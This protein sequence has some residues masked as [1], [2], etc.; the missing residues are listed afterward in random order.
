MPNTTPI[1]LMLVAVP[2]ALPLLSPSLP[3]TFAAAAVHRRSVISLMSPFDGDGALDDGGGAL[4]EIG[5]MGL[6][7]P[8]EPTTELSPEGVVLSLC[9]GLQHN[10]V[11]H[12]D[13][14][15]E[16]LFRFCTYECKA[17]LTTRKGYKDP[18]GK[19][20]VE[21]A[22]VYTLLGCRSFALVGESTIIAGTPT[23]GALATIAVDVEETLGFRFA[24][25]YE[26]RP[27]GSSSAAAASSSAAA[28]SE[29][30]TRSHEPEVRIER[31]RFT[32][33]QER[34]PPLAGCWMV[35]EL[36][37]MREF[38]LFNGDTGAVQG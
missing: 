26:R 30:E 25:G 22:Q 5:L 12:E 17:S 37:P 7:L 14:G 1:G 38:M 35:K 2:I 24:S 20:F 9:R 32:L 23:R 28:A 29:E 8:A 27:P 4:D 16:R 13:A 15:L 10:H 3:F 34:R 18:T 36:I 11:P 6:S 33:T 21:H 19:R 31:F